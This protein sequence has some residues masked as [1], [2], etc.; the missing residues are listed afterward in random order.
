MEAPLT[1]GYISVMESEGFRTE[2]AELRETVLDGF[3]RMDRYFELQQKQH[4]ELRGDVQELRGEVQELRAMLVALTAR[5]DALTERVDALTERVD[6]L[7]GTVRALRDWVTREFA[8]VRRELRLLRES[9]DGRYTDLRRDID[10]LD[11]RVTLLEQRR[12]DSLA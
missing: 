7:E 8:D 3:A 9:A 4:L 2:L 1:R 11:V 6:A 12:D 10:A 5:V